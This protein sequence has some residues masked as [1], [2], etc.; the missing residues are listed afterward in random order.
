MSHAGR[1]PGAHG[2]LGPLVDSGA[3]R[4][5]ITTVGLFGILAAAMM[6]ATM[7][8]VASGLGA[9][10]DRALREAGSSARDEISGGHLPDRGVT[11]IRALPHRSSDPQSGT[12]V[13]ALRPDGSLIGDPAP[14]PGLPDAAAVAAAGSSEDLRSETF[15]E[16]GIRLLTIKLDPP[17]SIGNEQVGYVQVGLITTMEEQ[18]KRRLF[19]S[20]LVVAAFGLAG[21]ALVGWAVTRRAMQ[22]I[23]DTFEHE[24]RFLAEASH[25]L[26]TPLAVLRSSAEV[27]ERE[28]HVTSKGRPLVDDIVA[29]ADR[30]GLIVDELHALA[31]LQAAPRPAAEPIEVA[32][33][34]G[35]A[36]ERGRALGRSKGVTVEADTAALGPVAARGEVFIRGS[37]RA[38]DEL[39]LIL[40][41]NAIRHSPKHGTVRLAAGVT[42][43]RVEIAVDD[44]GPGI[45]T[46]DRARIFEPF[47]RLAD[48]TGGSGLGLAIAREIV[49]QHGGRIEAADSP[50]GG[51]RLRIELPLARSNH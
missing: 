43:S 36:A 44:Q 34:V 15:D 50:A 19:V 47:A 17:V 41:E 33:L 48:D 28:G 39:L 14:L 20:M 12:F 49:A 5:L 3:R 27:L 26:R 13:L 25:Q 24:R 2:L 22:P 29:E 11:Q 30:M 45:P 38:L 10:V 23:C 32:G 40:I 7:F 1:Q 46:A 37:R 6:L 31:M 16:V 21:T 8:V 4:I 35:D 51:A 9:E 42:G 18:E